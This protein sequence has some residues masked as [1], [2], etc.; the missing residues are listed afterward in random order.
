MKAE[1]RKVVLITRQTRLEALIARFHTLGQAKFYIEH[2]GEKMSDYE[3]EHTNYMAA[4][5]LVVE[6]LKNIERKQIIDRKFLPNFMFAENDIVLALGQDGLVANTLKYLHGQP[7][8]GINPDATRYDGVLLP[9]SAK[10]IKRLLPD[11]MQNKRDAKTITMAEAQLN[12]GQKMLAVNDLFIG[13]KSH[14]SARYEIAF[15]DALENQSSSGIIVSTGLGS[16]GW[17]KSIITSATHIAQSWSQHEIDTDYQTL[18]WDAQNLRFAVREPFPSKFTQSNL[19]FGE[20]NA[21]NPLIVRSKMPE[22][23]VI[24]SDGIED[25]FIAFNAGSVATIQVAKQQGQLVI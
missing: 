2:L 10:D 15:G 20:I 6:S 11:L 17:M 22:N 5:N 16:T 9:F 14:V 7:L 23:A 25:D 19:V 8:I 4:K 18:A 3:T 1:A 13:A 21:E 24:F 12:D